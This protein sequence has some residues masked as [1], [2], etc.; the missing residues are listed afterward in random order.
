MC[1]NNCYVTVVNLDERECIHLGPPDRDCAIA[2]VIRKGFKCLLALLAEKRI[3]GP[4]KCGMEMT[5]V[6]CFNVEEV[7]EMLSKAGMFQ[8]IGHMSHL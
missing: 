2:C 6:S 1:G 8:W 3:Q 7:F 4:N 5:T